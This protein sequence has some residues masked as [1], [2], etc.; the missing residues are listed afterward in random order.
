MKKDEGL[1]GIGTDLARSILS[2]YRGWIELKL[3]DRRGIWSGLSGRCWQK[4]PGVANGRRREGKEERKETAQSLEGPRPSTLRAG[5][6]SRVHGAPFSRLRPLR[7]LSRA[8][9]TGSLAFRVGI[10]VL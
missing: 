7:P 5:T 10:F 4:G 3:V 2:I 9:S 6:P 8:L 1:S